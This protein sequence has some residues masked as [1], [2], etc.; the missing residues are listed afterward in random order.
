MCV[1]GNPGKAYF[2]KF[3]MPKNFIEFFVSLKIEKVKDFEKL[4]NENSYYSSEDSKI[5]ADLI[6]NMINWDTNERFT[7]E[8]CLSH[9]FFK[10]KEVEK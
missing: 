5:A 3:Q 4:I 9:P 2:D 7:A 6:L 10:E 1:L 8:Q